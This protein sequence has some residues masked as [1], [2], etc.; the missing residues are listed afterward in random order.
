METV[1]RTFPFVLTMKNGLVLYAELTPSQAA[2]GG[3]PDEAVVAF[4]DLDGELRMHEVLLGDV[5]A[6]VP[7]RPRPRG[8]RRR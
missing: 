3:P 8:E 2:T 4:Q 1:P 7:E 5:E 6:G